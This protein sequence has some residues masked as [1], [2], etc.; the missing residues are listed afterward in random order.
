MSNVGVQ[1]QDNIKIWNVLQYE[2]VKWEGV[3]DRLS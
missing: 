1:S 2:Y 3:N